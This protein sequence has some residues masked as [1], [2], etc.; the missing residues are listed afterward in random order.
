M[1]FVAVYRPQHMGHHGHYVQRIPERWPGYFIVNLPFHF[2]WKGEIKMVLDGSI[3]SRDQTNLSREDYLIHLDCVGGG[4]FL[5]PFKGWSETK[6]ICSQSYPSRCN[7][8]YSLW[9]IYSSMFFLNQ[10]CGFVDNKNVFIVCAIFLQ[11]LSWKHVKSK[12]KGS[13]NPKGHLKIHLL[14]AQLLRKKV[15]Y[16]NF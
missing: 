2:L 16:F 8:F 14:R 12:V 13:L 7:L 1:L 11:S 9:V 15:T 6:V 3:F 4:I 5:Y 10:I